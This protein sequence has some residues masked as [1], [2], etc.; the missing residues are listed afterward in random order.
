[1]HHPH[2]N[3]D[4]TLRF[5]D[6]FGR[7]RRRSAGGVTTG[8]PCLPCR[9]RLSS[10]SA[11]S[12][13]EW[14]RCLAP[15]RCTT[16]AWCCRWSLATFPQSTLDNAARRSSQCVTATGTWQ[17][18]RVLRQK[19]TMLCKQSADHRAQTAEHKT[20][21][22]MLYAY[23]TLSTKTRHI[24]QSTET[25]D[26]C[27]QCSASKEQTTNNKPQCTEH[28]NGELGLQSTKQQTERG[29]HKAQTTE[30]RPHTRV[31]W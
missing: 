9:S 4:E 18:R 11:A 28:Y 7:C 5:E 29:D 31:L 30:H 15:M 8:S 21:S 13:S 25:I 24:A 17:C 10:S 16:P 23:T 19:S 14:R 27:P 1:M 20:Q 22:T 2:A 6:S 3:R 12:T 26:H